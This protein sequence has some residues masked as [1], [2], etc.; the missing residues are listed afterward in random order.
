M[1]APCT[2][3]GSRC[4]YQ[5]ACQAQELARELQEQF[6]VEDE[7]VEAKGAAES[8]GIMDTLTNMLGGASTDDKKSAQDAAAAAAPPD[9]PSAPAPPSYEAA[10]AVG[11]VNSAQVNQFIEMGFDRA[12]VMKA[13]ADNNNDEGATLN[14][15]VGGM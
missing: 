4:V 7:A 8:P 3:A 14:A 12:T 11:A 13:L 10:T 2:A 9:V 15:L 1:L 5:L 6:Q